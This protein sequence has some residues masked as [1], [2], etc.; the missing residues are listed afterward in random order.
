M[1]TQCV[2][3][4]GSKAGGRANDNDRTRRSSPSRRGHTAACHGRERLVL[5]ILRVM[6]SDDSNALSK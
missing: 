1:H 5:A 2:C 3:I 6:M 4:M